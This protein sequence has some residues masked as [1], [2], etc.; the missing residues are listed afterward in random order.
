M[1][2]TFP[3]TGWTTQRQKTKR[4]GD[5]RHHRVSGLVQRL[6][7]GALRGFIAQRP[8]ERWV[9]GDIAMH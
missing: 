9:S 2:G 4:G 1:S 6:S 8:L 7:S 3:M 5:S